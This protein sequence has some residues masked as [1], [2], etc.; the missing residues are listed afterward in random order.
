MSI[1]LSA[2]SIEVAIGAEGH[3]NVTQAV[4]NLV[5]SLQANQI[6]IDKRVYEDNDAIIYDDEEGDKKPN[7]EGDIILEYKNDGSSKYLEITAIITH[8]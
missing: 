2:V 1:K 3:V 5:P 8:R 4:M 7:D 6:H